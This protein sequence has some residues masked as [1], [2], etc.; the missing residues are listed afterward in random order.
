[1]FV[2]VNVPRLPVASAT[3]I[4]SVAGVSD[5]KPMIG[6]KR[7]CLAPRSDGLAGTYSYITSRPNKELCHTAGVRDAPQPGQRTTHESSKGADNQ[8]PTIERPC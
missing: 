4:G 3:R 5:E 6:E 1:M 8:M 7:N 2:L